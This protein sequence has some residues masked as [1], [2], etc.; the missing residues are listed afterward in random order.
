VAAV[1]KEIRLVPDI[2][3]DMAAKGDNFLYIEN[4][5]AEV[6]LMEDL[7]LKYLL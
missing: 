6:F 5:L 3:D 4:F 1:L 7:L 2:K